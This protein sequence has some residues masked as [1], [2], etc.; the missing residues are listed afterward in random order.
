MNSER[1]KREEEIERLLRGA[2]LSR[3][4]DLGFQEEV[5]KAASAIVE[6]N[7]SRV[8]KSERAELGKRRISPATVGLWLLV[9]GAGLAFSIPSLGAPLIVCGIAVIV[10]TT[11]L[12]PGK[13]K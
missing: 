12:K 2:G 1:Q 6:E 9:I 3:E 11:F 5:R 10:W 7:S 4:P 8:E 13:K